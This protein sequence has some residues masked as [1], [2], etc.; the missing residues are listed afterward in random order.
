MDGSDPISDLGLG[1]PFNGTFYICKDSPTRFIGC[2]TLSPCGDRKGLCPDEHLVPATFEA[3]YRIPPQACINDNLAVSWYTCPDISPPFLGCCAVNPCSRRG[4]PDKELR[5]AKLSDKRSDANLFTGGISPGSDPKE[6][7][8]AKISITTATLTAS[9]I[10]TKTIGAGVEATSTLDSASPASH[11]PDEKN[12]LSTG[13]IVGISI[14]VLAVLF[15]IIPCIYSC[16]KRRRSGT[17]EN[18]SSSGRSTAPSSMYS[19]QKRRL[20]PNGSIYGITNEDR[21]I[22]VQAPPRIPSGQDPGPEIHTAASS[23]EQ[24]LQQESRERWTQQPQPGQGTL[25]RPRVTIPRETVQ[26]PNTD[27]TSR[28]Q[29]PYPASGDYMK[30]W[31]WGT[32]TLPDHRGCNPSAPIIELPAN[33]E[34]LLSTNLPSTP[35][36]RPRSSIAELPANTERPPSTDRPSTPIHR[37][38]P[39]DIGRHE[40]D[41]RQPESPP[42]PPTT[43]PGTAPLSDISEEQSV[44]GIDSSN[45]VDAIL[46]RQL[47]HDQ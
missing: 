38:I 47:S 36:D 24:H 41:P 15:V 21:I 11:P 25:P 28:P 42:R 14:A 19:Q 27:Q 46:E 20:S 32:Q 29:P 33:T 7:P 4:C 43:R 9:Y 22:E 40:P 1:C 45:T 31:D 26:E 13:A 44:G 23:G 18:Q 8:P 37:A 5:A 10:S 16:C 30:R 39:S 17:T 6:N 3:R 35:V 12:P 2:C 34:T